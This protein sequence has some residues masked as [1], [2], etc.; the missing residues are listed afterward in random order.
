MDGDGDGD[1]G[2]EARIGALLVILGFGIWM[3][4][5][6]KNERYVF[7]LTRSVCF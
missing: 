6:M 2:C 4:S 3:G 7:L 5:M 1:G